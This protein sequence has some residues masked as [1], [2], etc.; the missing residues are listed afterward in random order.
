MRMEEARDEGLTPVEAMRRWIGAPED[1]EAGGIPEGSELLTAQD[2]DTLRAIVNPGCVRPAVDIGPP[3]QERHPD[4]LS[5]F[6]LEKVGYP[7][8]SE[9][10]VRCLPVTLK[11]VVL[12]YLWASEADDAADYEPCAAAAP[13]GLDAGLV[14][15]PRLMRAW[16]EGLT[17]L[18]VLR[19]WKGEPEHPE[20][21]GIAADAEERVVPS[22][23]ALEELAR[24]PDD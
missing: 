20:A 15:G 19:R 12:G 18:Q 8:L 21:G 9:S 16:E 17:P 4:E 22:A 10:A 7:F 6:T 24:Q 1:P 5:P 3:E 11:G 13:A 2:E 14:W 23:D